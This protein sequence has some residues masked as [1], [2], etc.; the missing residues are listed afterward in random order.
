M[1]I[2]G[3]SISL[4]QKCKRRYQLEHQ[5]RYLLWHPNT[6]FSATMRN[7]IMA[8]SSGV[9]KQLVTMNAVNTFLQNVK[10]PGLLRVEGVNTYKL[11]MDYAAMIKTQIEYLSWVTLLTLKKPAKFAY[12]ADF[13]W[14][15]LSQADDSGVLHRWRFVDYINDDTITTETHSYELF[16][17]LALSGMPMTLHMVSIGRRDH[18]HH[19]SPWCKAYKSPAMNM[20]KFQKKSGNGLSDNWKPIYFA[21]DIDMDASTWVSQMLEDNII[22]NLVQHINITEPSS[23]HVLNLKRDLNYELMDILQNYTI[24]WFE[25]PMSRGACDSPYICPHQP[26]CFSLNPESELAGNPLYEKLK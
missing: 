24:P 18:D 19:V 11:A 23:V 20:Y 7:A 5:Y 21:D 8:L 26:L 10:Q 12:S 13:S 1:L 2:N 3:H 4:W 9:E 6:L 22:D 16:A 15:F 17:D 14:M 25:L